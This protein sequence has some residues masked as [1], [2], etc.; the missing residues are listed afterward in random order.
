M[1]NC[2]ICKSENIK[3]LCEVE[4]ISYK[5]TQMQVSI[6][7]SEC[8]DCGREFISKPQILRNEIALRAAKKDVDGLMASDKVA[9]ARIALCLTQEQASKVFGGGRNAFSKYERGEVAQSAAMDKLIRVCLKHQ[10]VFHEL[11]REAGVD[12]VPTQVRETDPTKWE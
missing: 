11:A 10:D 1:T 8:K 6:E 9:D 4:S 3:D 2:K 7:Y 5:G 12:I